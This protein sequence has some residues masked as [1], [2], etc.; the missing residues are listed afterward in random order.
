LQSKTQT[1]R[2]LVIKMLSLNDKPILRISDKLSNES[3]KPI[4][5][6]F[7]DRCD[8]LR[9]QPAERLSGG[10]MAGHSIHVKRKECLIV[11]DCVFKVNH[12]FLR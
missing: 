11:E 2:A 6:E 9:R 8:H 4:T 5:Q 10:S 12:V 7:D 1:Q 3:A